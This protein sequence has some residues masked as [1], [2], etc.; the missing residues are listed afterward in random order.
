MRALALLLSAVC[1][2]VQ[3]TVARARGGDGHHTVGAIADARIQGSNAEQHVKTLLDGG[4]LEQFAIWADCA[5]GPTYCR[6][7]PW[8]DDE[9]KAFA[10]ANKDHHG[11]HYTD[12]PIQESNYRENSV[13]AKPFDVVHII[14]QCIVVLNGT[15]TASTNPHNF[16]QRIAL[17]LLAHLVGDVH[18]PL[19][20][21]AAYVGENDTFVNPNTTSQ[22][23]ETQGGNFLMRTASNNLH[24][25]W[26]DT[27]VKQAMKVR[28]VTTPADL[29]VKL[30]EHEPAG[31]KTAGDTSVWPKAWADE[32]LA[33]ATQAHSGLALG[34]RA[35]VTDHSGTHLQWPITAMPANDQAHASDVAA[36]QITKAGYRLAELLRRIWRRAVDSDSAMNAVR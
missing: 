8:F 20:V 12:I 34:P 31:W 33:L 13:G 24:A 4:T 7:R 21:G 19:H 11:Y 14:A 9:M 2:L 16:S 6:S 36:S 3:P 26:D 22:F 18:Q 5:K 23:E 28:Q 17:I 1:A 29:A 25:F 27:S 10:K 32:T 15:A 35:A 30:G